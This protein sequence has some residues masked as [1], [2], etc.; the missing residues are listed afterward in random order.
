MSGITP[1]QQYK[2]TNSTKRPNITKITGLTAGL[3]IAL[4]MASGLTK[5][6]TLK[7]QHKNIAV[8]TAIITA[9]HVLWTKFGYPRQKHKK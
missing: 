2:Q 5:N 9:L 8:A 7:K 6:K 1:V 3:G 4:T